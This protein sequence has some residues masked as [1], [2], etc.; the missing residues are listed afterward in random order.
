[1][2]LIASCTVL[3]VVAGIYVL[4]PLFRESSGSLDIDLRA[5]TEADRLIDRKNAIYRNLKDLALEYEMGRLSDEDYSQ[6]Q[7]GYKKDAAIILQRLD[8]LKS[9]QNQD[10][11][12]EKEIAARKRKMGSGD[13]V[14]AEA[15]AKCSSCG[16]DLIPG[17][18]FCAD[19]G[20]KL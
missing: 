19:C 14:S 4:V 20:H 6:L 15:S 8:G 16:A 10:E 5:E 3:T 12:I 2:L 17:K 13:S 9:S 18:K 7:A 11:E 1:M